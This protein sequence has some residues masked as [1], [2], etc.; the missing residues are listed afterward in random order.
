MAKHLPFWIGFFAAA[1]LIVPIAV[2]VWGAAGEFAREVAA[3]TFGAIA[4]LVVLL[5]VFL[6]FRERILTAILGRGE[7]TLD[8][9]TGHVVQTVSA[10]SSGD[11]AKAEAEAKALAQTFVGWWAWSNLYRWVIATALGLLLAFGAFTGTVLLFEQTR[12]LSEQTELMSAQTDLMNAQTER[13]TEQAQQAAMQNEIMTLNLVS[14]LRDQLRNGTNLVRLDAYLKTSLPKLTD[15]FAVRDKFEAC[16]LTWR[17]DAQLQTTPSPSTIKAIVSIGQEGLL[18]E[19]VRDALKILLFDRD[20]GVKFGAVLALNQL[21]EVPD[22]T[23][24]DLEGLIVDWTTFSLAQH[25][26]IHFQSSYLAFLSCKRCV[27]SA[28]GSVVEILQGTLGQG[29]LNIEFPQ[30]GG[31]TLEPAPE[32]APTIYAQLRSSGGPEKSRRLKYD[33]AG[34]RIAR[35]A[36]PHMS[37]RDE[38]DPSYACQLFGYMEEAS[39]FMV[40]RPVVDAPAE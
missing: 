9:L 7:A 38:G 28:E 34:F 35:F 12:K 30:R 25:W 15:Q 18:A 11:R 39:D 2:G 5:V 6:F 21:E 16:E 1:L 32:G 20:N 8:D 31:E 26:T 17:Q 13:M 27:V 14:E 10:M 23:F 24:V 40:A 29:G 22:D 4:V 19:R 33:D 37:H 36:A 3:F